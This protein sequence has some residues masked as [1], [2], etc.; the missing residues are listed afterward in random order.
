[1]KRK[2][3]KVGLMI[4]ACIIF[5]ASLL[6]SQ[7][8]AGISVGL[9]YP[10][11]RNLGIR[12][13]N[14]QFQTGLQL[15]YGNELVTLSLGA[16]FNVYGEPKFNG[17]K[18]VYVKAFLGNHRYDFGDFFKGKID[19]G[20]HTLGIRG[21]YVFYFSKMFGFEVDAGPMLIQEL[22]TLPVRKIKYSAG[23][24]IGCSFFF[25]P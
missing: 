18:P 23:F 1:M 7:P 22:S 8:R 6:Y 17:A 9:G 20:K 5:P 24:G 2:K 21:G 12:Y 14:E 3:M 19:K 13:Q 25:V 16:G 15:G 11:G 10:E 4:F